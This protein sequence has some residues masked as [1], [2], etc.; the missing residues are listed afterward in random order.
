MPYTITRENAEQ[1]AAVVRDAL[2]VLREIG[3]GVDEG[4]TAR[5]RELADSIEEQ[6]K[7]AIEEPTEFGSVVRAT[8]SDKLYVLADPTDPGTPWCGADGFWHTWLGLGPVEVLRVGIG[9]AL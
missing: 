9:D 6:V 3:G 5:L 1:D 7:P 8:N 2:A 4:A